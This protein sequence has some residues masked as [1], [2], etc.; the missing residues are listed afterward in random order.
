MRTNLFFF[1]GL[2]VGL[3]VASQ[4]RGDQLEMQNGD[5]YF[6][7][8]LSVS[9]DNVV[10]ESEVLGKVNVPRKKVLSLT[11]GASAAAPAASSI[12]APLSLPANIPTAMS[13]ASLLRTNADLSG[14]ARCAWVND[15]GLA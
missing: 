4:V 10:L 8:V 9:A 2:A 5:R 12:A 1:S 13:T 11:F 3:F 6:G 15:H 14:T 7:K